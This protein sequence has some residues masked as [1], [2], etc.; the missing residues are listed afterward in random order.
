MNFSKRRIPS[1][2]KKLPDWTGVSLHRKPGLSAWAPLS[3]AI[4]VTTK[5]VSANCVNCYLHWPQLMRLL[6]ANTV[7]KQYT[8]ALR[9][10]TGATTGYPQQGSVI[11]QEQPA[12]RNA[13]LLSSAPIRCGQDIITAYC[14]TQHSA[15]N[16]QD[17]FHKYTYIYIHLPLYTHTS[18]YT[19][20]W[21]KGRPILLST[22]KCF[23]LKI[24]CCN[25]RFLEQLKQSDT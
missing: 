3:D 7:R 21:L 10:W 2:N 23:S 22:E 17:I 13:T 6:K 8:T 20:Y 19:Q 1:S 18:T 11:M 16:H 14:S 12:P 25:I 15:D 24:K 4:S 9:L 5:Q